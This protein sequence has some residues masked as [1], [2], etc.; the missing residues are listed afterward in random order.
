MFRTNYLKTNSSFVP[1]ARNICPGRLPN[2]L[3]KVLD[4]INY[5]KQATVF[6]ETLVHALNMVE[7]SFTN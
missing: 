4:L 7:C 6:T 3:C 2:E 5:R 1:H